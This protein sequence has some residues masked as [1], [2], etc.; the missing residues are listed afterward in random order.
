MQA[1]YLQQHNES[2]VRQ[3]LGD[4][5]NM[6]TSIQWPHGPIDSPCSFHTLDGKKGL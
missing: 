5:S 2:S 6:R 3:F 1:Y 4:D